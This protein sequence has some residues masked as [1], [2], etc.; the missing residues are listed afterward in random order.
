MKIDFIL[1]SNSSNWQFL[2]GKVE[3]YS[4]S[5]C[6]GNR[7]STVAECQ[8]PNKFSGAFWA[9]LTFYRRDF[10]GRFLIFLQY[11]FDNASKLGFKHE[12]FNFLF[13]FNAGFGIGLA[14]LGG[15]PK[16]TYEFK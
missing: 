13:N 2:N 3:S 14:N 9:H 12:S 6:S 4:R 1:L 15:P 7:F 8:C 16:D 11:F 5:E 10:S